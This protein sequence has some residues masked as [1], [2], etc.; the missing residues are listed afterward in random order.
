MA[1]AYPLGPDLKTPD[2]RLGHQ[3]FPAFPRLV[4]DGWL[5]TAH[6]FG[7]K[8]IDGSKREIFPPLPTAQQ[9][10]INPFRPYWLEQV[11]DDKLVLIGDS[12]ALWL[13][14]LK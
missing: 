4:I 5:W 13:I 8:S 11:G 12:A 3:P 6:P 2:V 7:R 14:H 1:D 9:W 10:T